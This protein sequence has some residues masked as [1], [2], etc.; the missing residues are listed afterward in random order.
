MNTNRCIHLNCLDVESFLI[1]ASRQA[2]MIEIPNLLRI[3]ALGSAVAAKRLFWV[4]VKQRLNKTGRVKAVMR[5]DYTSVLN[6]E[7]IGDY[8]RIQIVAVAQQ[9]L[10]SQVHLLFQSFHSFLSSSLSE[11]DF[12][13]FISLCSFGGE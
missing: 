13:L 4:G 10:P 2:S 8:T 1:E 9:S 11:I 7:S 5:G 12:L 3:G 6:K